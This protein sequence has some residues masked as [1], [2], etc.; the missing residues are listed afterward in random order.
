M[1]KNKFILTSGLL[2]ALPSWAEVTKL[3][4][5]YVTGGEEAIQTTP[6]SA[7]LL[8]ESEL[9]KFEYTDIHQVLS[10]VPGVYIRGEDGFGL[11]PNIGMRGAPAE[12]SQKITIME[13]GILITPAP[14]SA[15]SAYY[16]PNV[17]R[18]EG[19][20]VFK[21]PVAIQYG[22]N[23][24]GGALN[25][26]T[27]SVPH[28]FAGQVNAAG[29]TD[30]F[31]KLHAHV[32]DS[33]GQFS[34]LVEGLRFGS[35]GFKELDGGGDTGFERNDIM[36]KLKYTTPDD[37]AHYQTFEVKL[38]Y[39]DELS[40]ETYL[41]LTDNDFKA[42]PYRRYAASQLDLVDWDQQQ[43]L[44]SHFIELTPSVNLTTRAYHTRF[45]RSWNK[46]DDF[47]R[48]TDAPDDPFSNAVFSIS[49]VLANPTGLG[50][51]KYYDLLT[52]AVD[53][54]GTE[55][56]KI[57]VTNNDREYTTQGIEFSLAFDKQYK[58]IL[59]EFT[60]GLRFHQD[61]VERHHSVKS[62]NMISGNLVHDGV[63]HN[64]RALNHGETDAL[65]I[66]IKDK[67]YIN[68]WVIT[69]GLRTEFINNTY[70]DHLT[71]SNSND[72]D[73]TVV[74]PGIGAFYQYNTHLGF[75]AGIHKGFTPNA[76]AP[77]GQ[78]DP[79]ESIN[80]EFGLRYQQ[81]K[82]NSEAI[83]FYNKYGNLIG[84][85]RTSDDCIEGTEFN[86]G[87]VDIYGLELSGTVNHQLNDW[88]LPIEL[89]Y[90]YTETEFQTSFFSDFSQWGDVEKGDELPYVPNHQAQLRLGLSKAE[91]DFSL[92]TKYTG[93]MRE[94]AG[95]GNI[96]NSPHVP[97]YYIVDF[98]G[99]YQVSKS[100]RLQLTIDNVFDKVEIVS[101]RPFG[102]RPNKPRTV[103]AAVKYDF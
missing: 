101:R 61:E 31:H 63:D 48:N 21:G 68:D 67:A 26:I 1:K 47:R 9:E 46:F 14:Y 11:R 37:S 94:V 90:T 74:I 6:G 32:G 22:P 29:G 39:A 66:F 60:T 97:A 65:A 64:L 40:D 83:G 20:E 91:W 100:L 33:Q 51:Q 103:I 18:M 52:G 82:L 35:D 5:V 23:T 38:G 75:L 59:H 4:A 19:V 86:G 55:L 69:A 2:L 15:P 28:E 95:Q 78:A 57:D 80:T 73:T 102:A 44:L 56:Q 85:C 72:D 96:K 17:A 12:R 62:Y 70:T 76:P 49:E 77:G 8:D 71:P 84:R 41:G 25:L 7:H 3:E 98:A 93:E 87:E 16:F 58:G 43:I 54:N 36:L 99:S 10:S 30:G 92:A 13:D 34:W 50:E 88:E 45:Q 53:S 89:T 24:V 81:G 79:E 27:T 42:S